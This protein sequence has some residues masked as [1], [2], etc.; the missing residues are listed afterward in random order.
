MGTVKAQCGGYEDYSDSSN[1]LSVGCCMDV[2]KY[3]VKGRLSSYQAVIDRRLSLIGAVKVLGVGIL[4]LG[5]TH[6]NGLL[7]PGS[8]Y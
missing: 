3:P 6:P 4:V 2:G 1:I 7:R 8:A 5:Y